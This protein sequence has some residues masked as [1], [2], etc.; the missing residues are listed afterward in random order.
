MEKGAADETNTLGGERAGR[1]NIYIYICIYLFIY[2]TRWFS[3]AYE[4]MLLKQATPP[5]I[6]KGKKK[7]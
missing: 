5:K 1:Q 4:N 2:L 3:V 6:K 7:E